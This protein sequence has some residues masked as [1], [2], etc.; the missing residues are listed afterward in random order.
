MARLLVTLTHNII[1]DFWTM[2][3]LQQTFCVK[4]EYNKIMI[5]INAALLLSKA[6]P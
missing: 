4:Y 3:L 1:P 2:P 5:M 6:S